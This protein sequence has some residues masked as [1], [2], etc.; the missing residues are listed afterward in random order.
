MRERRL[1]SSKSLRTGANVSV[2][3]AHPHTNPCSTM[4]INEVHISRHPLW[5]MFSGSR[6]TNTR[7]WCSCRPRTPRT[8]LSCVPSA[9]LGP[10]PKHRTEASQT[11]EDRSW[12]D[13]TPPTHPALSPNRGDFVFLTYIFYCGVGDLTHVGTGGATAPIFQSLRRNHHSST[14]VCSTTLFLF[15]LL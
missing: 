14:D 2:V 7:A 4:A 1:L 3:L 12:A 15:H 8:G 6:Q 5:M 9:E 11:T 13:S 10:L